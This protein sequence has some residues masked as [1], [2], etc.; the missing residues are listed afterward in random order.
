MNHETHEIHEKILCP[1]KSYAIQAV[2]ERYCEML[3][4]LGGGS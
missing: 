1:D 4:I 2:L 3:K